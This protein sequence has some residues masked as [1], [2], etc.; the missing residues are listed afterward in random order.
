MPDCLI[1]DSYS[2]FEKNQT[3][4]IELVITK[5]IEKNQLD[6]KILKS[7]KPIAKYFIV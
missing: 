3:L 6:T 2:L 4:T 1:T 5:E 7:L